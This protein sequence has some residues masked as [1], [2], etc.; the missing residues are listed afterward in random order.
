M[1]VDFRLEKLSERELE[2]LRA[3]LPQLMLELVQSGE[4]NGEEE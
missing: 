1:R 4:A 2:A 3:I